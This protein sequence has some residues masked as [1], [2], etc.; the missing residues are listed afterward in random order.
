MHHSISSRLRSSHRATFCECCIIPPAVLER[1]SEDDKFSAAERKVLADM[2]KYE[3]EWRK[4]RIARGRTLRSAQQ[5][6]ATVE[7]VAPISAPVVSVY[8]CR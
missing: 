2:V 5:F 7:S 4:L 6:L 3:K 1:L 8:N